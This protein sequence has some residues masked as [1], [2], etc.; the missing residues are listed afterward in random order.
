MAG[1]EK[2]PWSWQVSSFLKRSI[3]ES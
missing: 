3:Q 2:V 1:F